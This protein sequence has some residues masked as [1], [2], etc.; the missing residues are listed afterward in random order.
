MPWPLNRKI[1]TVTILKFHNVA[2][3]SKR[4]NKESNLDN[5]NFATNITVYY[6]SL[7][8]T[9][10]SKIG[11]RTLIILQVQ[12]DRALLPVGISFCINWGFLNPTRFASTSLVKMKTSLWLTCSS[13]VKKT[14]CTKFFISL[15]AFW[16]WFHLTFTSTWHRSEWYPTFMI[17][18][19]SW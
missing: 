3:A 12:L 14:L 19:T 4:Y 18:A 17:L 11:K 9:K 1:L 2:F 10:S 15:W 13:S 7:F 16:A 8:S 5:A 6:A